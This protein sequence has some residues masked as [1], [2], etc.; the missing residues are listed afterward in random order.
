MNIEDKGDFYKR[1]LSFLASGDIEAARDLLNVAPKKLAKSIRL[2]CEGNIHFYLR[3]FQKAADL[4]EAAMSSDSEYDVARYHYLVGLQEEKSDQL[5][6]A[7]K[8]Y[9]AAIEIEPNF[10]DAYLQ[11][12]QLLYKVEDYDGSLKCFQ[13]ALSLA[14]R[15]IGIYHNIVEVVKALAAKNPDKYGDISKEF[16]KAYGDVKA[17]RI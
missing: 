7:F 14:P 15:E 6:E 2:E 8:R 3:E 4:Y 10:V 11:L 1:H 16:E 17:S 13:D 12:G 5:V 9:Q